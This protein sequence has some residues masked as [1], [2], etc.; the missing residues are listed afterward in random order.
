MKHINELMWA[1]M[2][3]WPVLGLFAAAL[4]AAVILRSPKK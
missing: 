1:G 2:W 3:I 4:L